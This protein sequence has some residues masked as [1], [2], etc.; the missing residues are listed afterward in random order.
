MNSTPLSYLIDVMDQQRDFATI[1]L[2]YKVRAIDTALRQFRQSTNFP[3]NLKKGTLKI[4]NGVDEYPISADHGE[5][6]YIDKQ[7]LNNYSDTARFF[8][9]NLQQFKEQVDSTRNLMSDVWKDGTRYI[10]LKMR[11]AGLNQVM[12]DNAETLSRYTASDDA[13]GAELDNIVYREGS[14]SIKFTVTNSADIATI[15]NTTAL[16]QDTDYKTKYQFMWVYLAAVPESIELRLNTDASNYLGTIVTTQFAGN[17]FVANDWNLIAH[18]LNEATETGTFDETNI[19]S[20]T[21]ILNGAA[22]G[23]YR[24]DASYLRQWKLLDK[25]YYSKY[26]VIP[27]G[28]STPEQEYFI[29]ITGDTTS[30]DLLDELVGDSKWIDV[31]LGRAMRTLLADIENAT[32]LSWVN[33]FKKDA[34][35]EFNSKYPSMTPAI[36]T[37]R[38]RFDDDPG[39][40]YLR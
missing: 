16:G 10:G 12:A 15:V 7:I 17:A 34:E 30:I 24:V 13:S 14:G 33:E 4:F 23:V 6:A 38:R 20:E 5:I 1:E 3:W 26:N 32:L 35:T 19:T 9:T 11:D 40:A 25:W 39:L 22:N 36:T 37:L 8:N 2:Q 31:I 21:T 18:D 27:S 29:P 28:S